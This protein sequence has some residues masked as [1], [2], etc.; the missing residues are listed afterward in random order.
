MLE[1]F[2][3]HINQNLSFLKESKLLVAISGGIDSVVLAHLCHQLQFDF[4]L[5]H[6]NFKLRY[7]DSDRDA[8]F[9]KNLANNFSIQE[10]H[11]E[12]DTTSYSE[13]HNISTQMAA[14]ELRYNWFESLVNDFEYDYILTAHHTNDNIETVLINF[15]RGT[16]LHG[17][18]G[19]PEVNSNIVRP[20]LPFT[21]AAIE[22]FTITQ[23]IAWRE[24]ESNQS[25]KYVRNKIRHKVVPVLEE[26]NTNLSA[27][28][29]THLTYL[30]KEAQVLTQHLDTVK[31]E[32]CIFDEQ[33]KIDI[34]KLVMYDTI[35][36]GR[37][38]V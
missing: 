19:I 16:S 21:R 15:T 1:Q 20:L 29:N 33:L 23:N 9:V 12:F 35:E 27:T 8:I 5:A 4:S 37:A 2:K 13:E 28:F 24:D 7:E 31:N 36:I 14:R 18:T 6:C 30:K 3:Q 22:Q 38:H 25:T 32:V 26:L 10:H 17:L 34:N 11:I